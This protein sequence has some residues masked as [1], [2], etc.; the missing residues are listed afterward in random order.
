MIA[1]LV[2]MLCV[3]SYVVAPATLA[4]GPKVA[5]AATGQPKVTLDGKPL[6]GIGV[7]YY[8]AFIKVLRDPTDR[9][10]KVG[11][12]QLAQRRIPFIR[13]VLTGFFPSDMH[14]YMK[15]KTKFYALLDEFVGEAEKSGIGL[16][17]SLFF[18]Y[19]QV[20]DMVG[21]PMQAWGD[22]S[23][24]T[25]MFMK[26]FVTEVVTR[27]R[28][29]PAIWGWEFSN[30]TSYSVDL[31]A[32][33]RPRVAPRRGTPDRRTALDDLRSS[34]MTMAKEA[35]AQLVIKLDPTRLRVTGDALPRADAYQTSY[36]TGKR[37]D[38]R[39]EFFQILKRDNPDS[40]N[41]LSLHLYPHKRYFRDEKIGFDVRNLLDLV[42]GYSDARKQIIFVGE[43][44]VPSRS[45]IPEEEERK[46]FNEI[47]E[48]IITA[49]VQLS[50]VWDYD[51]DPEFDK[52]WNIV[53]PRRLYQLDAVE[54]ANKKLSK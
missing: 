47:L 33:A 38:S 42:R 26:E 18:A 25:S 35:F 16:I 11:F 24:R 19:W 41:A 32:K 46:T 1:R 8:N 49:G 7:N 28:N 40:Y 12:S 17:P 14:V 44:G 21:E 48:G 51:P 6:R 22:A 29:S 27:Y 34:D 5:V 54:E 10:Y 45:A 52:E 4:A 2:F 13:F 53:A 15:D 36:R 31:D 37:N 3:L 50:A 20:P 30:E 39:Q 9:S 23:S 43:F